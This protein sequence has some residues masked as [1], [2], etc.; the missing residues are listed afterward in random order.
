MNNSKKSLI[1]LTIV[2]TLVIVGAGLFVMPQTCGQSA[3]EK[4]IK[5]LFDH[6]N[7]SLQ[8]GDP[9]K[10]TELYA[11]RSILLPTLSD[12][13]RLTPKEK[14]DYFRHFLLKKP[15]AKID[16]RQIEIGKDM[17]VDTGLY[18]F[19]FAKTG[20]KVKARYSFVYKWDGK[21]WLIVSHHSSLI[22]ADK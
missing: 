21:S 19:T 2:A 4:E 9:Q 15:L 7:Q 12:K 3:S 11:K 8:T 6:W 13:V 14:E 1:I 5:S 20:E 18:T 17:V 10:V 16:F 22:P